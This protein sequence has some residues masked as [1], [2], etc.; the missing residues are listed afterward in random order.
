[1]KNLEGFIFSLIEKGVFPGISILVGKREEILLKKHYGDKSIEPRKEPL[2]EN[3][4]YDLASL[5]KPLITAFLTLYLVEK[6]RGITLETPVKKIF[7]GYPFDIRLVHLLT[8]TSGLP[9]WYPFYLYMAKQDYLTQLESLKPESRPGGPVNYSCVGYILL[10]HILERI[11]GIPF[12]TFAREVIFDPLGL[13]NTFL[14]VPEDKKECV[15]PTENGDVSE[16]QLALKEHKEASRVFQWRD[17][18]ICGE[19]HDCN[20]FYL[21][22]TA[23]NSGLFADTEDVFR[24]SREFQ[25]DAASILTPETIFYFWKNYTTFK[26]SHRTIGFKRNSSLITSGG[27]AISRKSIGHNGVTGTCLWIEPA[28]GYTFILL[29]NRVHPVVKDINFN[30]ILRKLHRLLTKFFHSYKIDS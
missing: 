6:E 16:R 17:S 8:H 7:P 12:K 28:G 23:G 13:K 30:K 9:G 4:L 24:L 19:A 22:G 29:T 18:I 14:S 10:Y 21:G 2:Q 3:T 25:P 1:M 20:S 11:T 5:T 27:R 26:K 15:A